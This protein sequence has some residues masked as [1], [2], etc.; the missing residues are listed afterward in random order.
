MDPKS[1]VPSLE[2]GTSEPYRSHVS[3]FYT[4]TDYFFNFPYTG[5]NEH[6]LTMTSFMGATMSSDK[7]HV[8]HTL[9]MTHTHT[10]THTRKTTMID[11]S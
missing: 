7:A 9:S 1:S 3:P 8:K 6:P 11:T 4:I 2:D 5:L 10:H